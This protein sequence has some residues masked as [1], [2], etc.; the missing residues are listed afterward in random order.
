M[1]IALLDDSSAHNAQM[2]EAILRICR[3]EQLPVEI[4]LEATTFEEIQ[5]LAASDPLQSV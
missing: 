1:N 4:R 5:A 2:R 3:E